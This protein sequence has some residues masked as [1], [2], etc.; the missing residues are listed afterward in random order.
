MLNKLKKSHCQKCHEE[1]AVRFCLRSNKDLGWNC[2]NALRIDLK[3]PPECDYRMYKPVPES[4]GTASPFP[5]FKSDS[6]TEFEHLILN[7]LNRWIHQPLIELDNKSPLQYAQED[8]EAMLK[9]LR[10]FRYS[11]AFP[12]ARLLKQLGIEIPIQNPGVDDPEGIATLYFEAILKWDWEALVHLTHNQLGLAGCSSRY[13]ELISNILLLRKTKDFA[14]VNC[15]TSEDKNLAFVFLELNHKHPWTVILSKRDGV[16]KL[17]QNINGDPTL[18]Y[19]QNQIYSE[20]AQA[21]GEGKFTGLEE[22]LPNALKLYPDSADLY[23][24]QALWNQ[25][26]KC[27]GKAKVDFFNA[28]SLDNYWTAP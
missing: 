21:L 16:W 8:A 11:E 1:R 28:I 26:E 23:Y 15:G 9:W 19:A 13:A 10:G 27:F 24:Y 5:S 12:L 2:C 14:I 7:Y 22:K 18:Y 4:S 20:L 25:A 17:R 6:R 3:C